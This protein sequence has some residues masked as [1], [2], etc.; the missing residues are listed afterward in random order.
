MSKQK[1]LLD[2]TF[3][4]GKICRVYENFIEVAGKS[5]NLE[6]LT[7]IH[8]TY[9][10][11][12]GVSSA[13]LDLSFGPRR[14]TLRGIADHDVARQIV[15]HLLTYCPEW[16]T[17]K[18]PHARPI[19]GRDLV[20]AQARAWERTNKLPAMPKSSQ[21]SIFETETEVRLATPEATLAT[22]EQALSESSL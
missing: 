9:R 3:S 18:G 22:P 5:Y 12:F 14:L 17:A 15:S 20:R 13:R 19:R 16:S 7:S 6:N 2:C 4:W 11:M 1:V 8:P 10:K 21:D